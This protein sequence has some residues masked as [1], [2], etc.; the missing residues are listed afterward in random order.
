MVRSA[1]TALL[2][3]ICFTSVLPQVP[4]AQ[5]N[6]VVW[7]VP[8]DVIPND[9]NAILGI[10]RAVGLRDPEAVSVPIR[11]TC[12]L[13][14][15]ES[16]RVLLGNRVLSTIV[17]IR[18]KRGPGCQAF[19]TDRPLKQLR[20]WVAFLGPTNPRRRER[21]RIHDAGWHVDMYLG[22]DVPTATL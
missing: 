2:S 10:A 22:S 21:W 8:G 20:N 12:L 11:S 1:R 5:G 14:E 4:I 15:V 17:G 18:Q 19:D 16:K 3:T 6:A 13:V 7:Q 9:R